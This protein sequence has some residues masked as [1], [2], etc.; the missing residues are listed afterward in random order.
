MSGVDLRDGL[1]DELNTPIRLRW[2]IRTFVLG[3]VLGALIWGGRK[4]ADT[5]TKLN[6]RQAIAAY[7]SETHTITRGFEN[8]AYGTYWNYC[9]VWITA[10]HVDRETRGA[11]PPG[12]SGETLSSINI[13]ATFYGRSWSCP[14]PIDVTEGQAVWIAG[15]PGGSDTIALRSGVVYIKRSSSGSD[16]YAYPTW[17]VVFP[18]NNLAAWLSE[19][20]AGG[21]SGG[22]VIDAET[23]APVGILVT[24]NSPTTLPS[25]GEVH[26]AD[27]VSLRDAYNE[28][29]AP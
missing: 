10:G 9:G 18:K 6:E 29:L 23:R 13:D 24:Q 2:A 25:F 15:Y 17:V 26:S 3:I 16:G 12:V 20:V 11:V 5:A 19:P 1:K 4:A 14:A 28:L 21:M 22:I 8:G 27:I 7:V